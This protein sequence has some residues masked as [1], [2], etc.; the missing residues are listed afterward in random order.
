MI[1]THHQND[2]LVYLGIF[3]RTM[4]IKMKYDELLG[5]SRQLKPAYKFD[6][7]L[8]FRLRRCI[9]IRTSVITMSK[10]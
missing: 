5:L 9:L 6:F 4:H 1:S 7:L 10:K 2:L 3:I 8:R